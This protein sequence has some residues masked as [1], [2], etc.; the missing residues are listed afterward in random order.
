ML[1]LI[2]KTVFK[3]NNF[4]ALTTTKLLFLACV[5]STDNQNLKTTGATWLKDVTNMMMKI[6]GVRVLILMNMVMKYEGF[7][8]QKK[9]S[10]A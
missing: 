7:V 1:L 3:A 6:L 2:F 10:K 8:N 5:E 4:L 9:H